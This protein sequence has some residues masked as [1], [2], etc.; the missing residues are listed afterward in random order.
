MDR[1]SR[2]NFRFIGLGVSI[3][4]CAISIEG[5]FD[6]GQFFATIVAVLFFIGAYRA[7]SGKPVNEIPQIRDSDAELV[8]HLADIQ[9]IVISIDERLRRLERDPSGVEPSAQHN[10]QSQALSASEFASSGA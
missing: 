4:V 8:R 2:I 3:F 6:P 9:E 10:A 5:D 1:T 7:I